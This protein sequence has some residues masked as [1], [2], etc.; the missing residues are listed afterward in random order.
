MSNISAE[1]AGSAAYIE[2]IYPSGTLNLSP[3]T[4][5]VTVTPTMDTIDAT[6]GQDASRQFLPSFVSYEVSWEGVAQGTA[7]NAG[8]TIAQALEAGV[9]GTVNIGPYGTA[10]TYLK[11]T[12]PA[13][14]RGCVHTMPYADVVTLSCTF[15]TS[16]GGTMD[17]TAYS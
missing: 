2:W 6:A 17:V 8:S 11:Y 4:R 3:H 1:Y 13:F 5:N 12:M 9:S 7:S 14:S 15:A 10:A 16:S